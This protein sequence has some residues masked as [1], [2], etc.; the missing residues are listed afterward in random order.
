MQLA[1]PHLR[2]YKANELVEAVPEDLPTI[3][4][5]KGEERN[6]SLL[7]SLRF[8]LDRLGPEALNWLSRLWIFEGGAMENALLA[9]TEIPEQTW[10][11]LK[12][13]LT[14]T[15]LIREEEITGVT[16]PFIHFH[17]T[18]APYLRAISDTSLPD[19]QN[20]AYRRRFLEHL[21]STR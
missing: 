4:V 19:F 11:A 12:P 10:N 20:V 18:L 17:P 16:T 14:S 5:G 6:K 8:S 1:L 2:K 21:L 7:M 13:Q 15:A 3:K 9:I